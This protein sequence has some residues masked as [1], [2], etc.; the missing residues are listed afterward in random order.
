MKYGTYEVVHYN[1][2]KDG[3]VEPAGMERLVLTR[4]EAVELSYSAIVISLSAGINGS[5][6]Y[7]HEGRHAQ[8][9]GHLGWIS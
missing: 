3:R 5:R 1:E 9:D 2:R 8:F 6:T 4:E 7:I